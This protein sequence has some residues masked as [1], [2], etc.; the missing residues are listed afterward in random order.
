MRARPLPASGPYLLDFWRL[1]DK[2]RLRKNPFYWD[3][4]NTKSGIVDYLCLSAPNTALNL[5]ETGQADI[6][7]DLTILPNELVDEL[8]KRPDYHAFP[9]LGT[10]FFRFNTTK[11]PF[12]DPR[13]RRA[14]A[15]AID[16]QRLVDKFLRGGETV[17]EPSGARRH[18]PLQ[19]GIRPGLRSRPGPAVAGRGRLSRRQRFPGLPYLFDAASGGGMINKKLASSCNRCGKGNWASTSGCNKWKR[20]FI[21]RRKTVWIT[22]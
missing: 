13:V 4:A 16:K 20:K 19:A 12:D 7:W 17:A 1:N 3:A 9:Y 5:Y 21:C 8:K 18:G 15:L 10:Y 14:L 6:I 22:I 2:I 11:Q